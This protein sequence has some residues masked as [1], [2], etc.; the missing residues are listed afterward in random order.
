MRQAWPAN[1]CRR[2]SINNFGYGGTN[3]HV[4]IEKA[5]KIR[6]LVENGG[7]VTGQ[8]EAP[9][10]FVL[11]AR[12]ESTVIKM[13]SNLREHLDGRANVAFKDLAFTLG[14]RRSRFPWSLAMSSP[15]LEC[16]MSSI[17]EQAFKP[18]QALGRHPRLGFGF[19]GQGAQWFAMGRSLWM[20]I[21]HTSK[22]SQNANR[23]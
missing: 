14:Q 21:L 2:A 13:G 23:P 3:A 5:P 6:T 16:L 12:D 7:E 11:S 22:L 10:L 9:K 17:S 15:S 1:Y 8:D 18:V 19:N 20:S 4:I